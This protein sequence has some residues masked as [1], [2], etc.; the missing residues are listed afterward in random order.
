MSY[1]V[2]GWVSVGGGGREWMVEDGSGEAANEGES[3]RGLGV[4]LL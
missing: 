4:R 1:V 2:S 3:V